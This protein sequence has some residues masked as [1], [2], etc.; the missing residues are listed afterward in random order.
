MAL[1][2]HPDGSDGFGSSVHYGAETDLP[3][4]PGDLDT[5]L[6]PKSVAA[7][8][9]CEVELPANIPTTELEVREA[10]FVHQRIE[11]KEEPSCGEADSI[12]YPLDGDLEHA[13]V[14]AR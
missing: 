10:R 9:G 8:T 5:N 6:Q 4:R 14:V 12:G 2:V 3:Q 7:I 11:S 1:R 13:I